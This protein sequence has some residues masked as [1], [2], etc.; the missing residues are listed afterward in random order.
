VLKQVSAVELRYYMVAS[1]YRS[2]VEFSY[3][4]V[5]EAAVGFR[6][7]T[8]LLERFGREDL[9][10]AT[11]ENCPPE[12][13]AAMDD[14]LGTPAAVAV[15]FETV[16]AGNAALERGDVQTARAA[17]RSVSAMASVLGINPLE[18]PWLHADG[19]SEQA[20]SALGALVDDQLAARQQARADKDWARADAIRDHL[21]AAGI[22]IE[23]RPSGPVWSLSHGG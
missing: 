22:V 16:R 8:A 23:D 14:D 6:R 1:H 18:P 19:D 21:A 7:V 10:D 4:A 2:M 11:R 15:M 13:V 12:F 3:E 17:W 5:T 20:L 9:P